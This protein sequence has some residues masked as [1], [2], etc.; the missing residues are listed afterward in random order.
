MDISLRR[1]VGQMFPP[2]PT[3]TVEQIPD[4]SGKV[5]LV[6]GG[7]TGIGKETCKQLLRKNA[8]VVLAARSRTKAEA[9][10]KE[11]ED[12]TGQAAHFLLLDLAD[13]SSVK[14]AAVE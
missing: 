10:I 2:K 1:I 5:C 9:A 11:L 3:W 6:T 8:T 13:L 12:E 14:T 7:N 4:L